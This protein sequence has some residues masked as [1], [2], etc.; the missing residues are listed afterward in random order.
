M[1][2]FFRAAALAILALTAAG[3]AGAQPYRPTDDALVLERLP[4]GLP[5]PRRAIPHDPQAAT[6]LAR[7]YLERA[8][9]HADPRFVGYAEQLLQPWW[10]EALPPAPVLLLRATIRQARHQFDEA[11]ADLGLL[12]ARHPHDGQALLTRATVLRVQGRHAEAARDCRALRGIADPFVAELCEQSVRGL[13]GGLAEAAAALDRLAPQMPLQ[14]A[15]VQAWYFAER[16]DM[17]RRLGRA[18]QAERLHRLAIARLLADPLL[19]ATAA[20]LLLESGRAQDALAIVGAAP[21]VDALRLRAALARRA[22]GQ[23]DA[24]TERAL[25]DA[26]AAARRRGDEAHL[27]EEARFELAIRSDAAAALRLAQDNWRSQREPED[28]RL[29]LEAAR[30]AN[31][32]AATEPVRQWLRQ[33]GLQDAALATLLDGNPQP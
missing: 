23:P 28:A 18:G 9:Q 19:V 24:V 16:A 5:V 25:A 7:S 2:S 1:P 20:D 3:H 4:A 30:A 8:R 12:L 21:A 17:A 11:L 29:L 33:S 13:G 27:R 6:A 32:P 31:A 14:P 22:L 10:S 15:G 26:Y